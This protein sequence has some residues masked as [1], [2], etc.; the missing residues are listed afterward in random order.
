MSMISVN[1]KINKLTVI[2]ERIFNKGSSYRKCTCECGGEKLIRETL[3]VD[4][5]ANDC[6]CGYKKSH[7]PDT[8]KEEFLIDK[9]MNRRLR[10]INEH[11]KHV[12]KRYH[13]WVILSINEDPCDNNDKRTR[14]IRC[15]VRCVCGTIRE[16]TINSII[17][18]KSKSCGCEEYRNAHPINRSHSGD[19]IMRKGEARAVINEDDIAW[20]DGVKRMIAEKKSMRE[21]ML[22]NNY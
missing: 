4:K 16:N 19:T 14:Y 3:L 20:M 7:H 11:K 18:G 13:G 6:G 8:C 15:K 12:G 9:G 22:K 5:K 1:D 2:S 17:T 21:I 10:A